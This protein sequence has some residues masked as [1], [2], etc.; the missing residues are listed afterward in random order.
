MKIYE[1]KQ[2]LSAVFLQAV[3]NALINNRPPL[4]GSGLAHAPVQ[5]IIQTFEMPGPMGDGVRRQQYVGAFNTIRIAKTSARN[6]D[7]TLSMSFKK[8]AALHMAEQGRKLSSTPTKA[9]DKIKEK[10]NNLS[11]ER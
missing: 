5:K 10:F 3:T 9:S 11:L 1:S 4:Q 8:A 6:P 7:E 2:N